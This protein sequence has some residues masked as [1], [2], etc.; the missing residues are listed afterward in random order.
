MLAEA[1]F[2]IL[3]SLDEGES[4]SFPG[5]LRLA[6]TL[7]LSIGSRFARLAA[8]LLD[9]DLLQLLLLLVPNDPLVFIPCSC[10]IFKL[11]DEI[12]GCEDGGQF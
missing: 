4:D 3:L 11:L 5:I 9:E 10:P 12:P 6:F 1:E 2:R 7:G 8:L